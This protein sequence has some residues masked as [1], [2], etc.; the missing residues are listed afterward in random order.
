M[1]PP[2]LDVPDFESVYRAEFAYVYR[3]L[4]Y[5]GARDADIEDLA[6]DVFIVVHRRLG[7]F[8][9]SRPIRPW[10]FGIAY[11]VLVRHRQRSSN[12]NEIATGDVLEAP[13]VG[14]LTE[15]RVA[16]A[17]AWAL[18]CAVVQELP[19]EQRAVLVMHDVEGYAAPE[20]SAA[21]DAPLNTVYSRLRLA[22][23]RFAVGLRQR[24]IEGGER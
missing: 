9:P 14:S 4:R 13:C 21:V 20:I 8:D 18:V 16:A 23:A 2:V 7:T 24:G 10:L 12:R 19:L 6:H 17:Q 22:R 1:A 11:H 3:A 15:E 5:L